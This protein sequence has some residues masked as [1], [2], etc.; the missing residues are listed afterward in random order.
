[1]SAYSVSWQDRRAL[2]LQS[3]CNYIAEQ[4]HSG[5]RVGR[6]IKISARKFRKRSLGGGRRLPLPEKTMQRH[7]YKWRN[8]REISV[9]A[10]HYR[11]GRGPKKI[12]PIFLRRIAFHCAQRGI[13]IAAAFRELN[14]V[15]GIGISVNT[16][17]RRVPAKM[18]NRLAALTRRALRDQARVERHRQ[19]LREA[20]LAAV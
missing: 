20:I 14:A 5:I 4:V 12:D 8:S 1:M 11:S 3:A 2:I 19:Q 7:W 6:A 9:F 13:S 17:Y 15:H 18:I 10:L 16:L